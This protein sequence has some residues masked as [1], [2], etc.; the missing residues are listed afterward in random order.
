MYRLHQEIVS[1]KHIIHEDSVNLNRKSIEVQELKKEVNNWT[2]KL[3]DHDHGLH[4]MKTERNLFSKN[5]SEAKVCI[6]KHNT[7]LFL[8]SMVCY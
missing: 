7:I 6:I 4:T 2:D 1:L 3:K 5:L 8:R